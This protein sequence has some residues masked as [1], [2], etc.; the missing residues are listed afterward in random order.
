MCVEGLGGD[1]YIFVSFIVYDLFKNVTNSEHF[2][3]YIYILVNVLDH[4]GIVRNWS[5]ARGEK[6]CEGLL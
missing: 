5:S 6:G 3:V 2:H 1:M 4:Q